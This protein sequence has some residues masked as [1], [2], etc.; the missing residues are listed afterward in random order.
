[1]NAD[2]YLGFSGGYANIEPQT[3]PIEKKAGLADVVGNALEL[4]I[5]S[6]GELL[7]YM[8]VLP[9]IAGGFGGHI[10]SRITSP[11]KLDFKTVQKAIELSD[12]RK[13]ETDVARR[14]VQAEID[15]ET[16]KGGSNAR[17]LRI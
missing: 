3:S 10:H 6:A 14:K 11:S 17:A 1:M 2:T 7:P 15:E 5:T 16:K 12:L 8:L 4:G 13:L 9:A